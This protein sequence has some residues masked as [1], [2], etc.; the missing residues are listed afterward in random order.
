MAL[1]FLSL[2]SAWRMDEDHGQIKVMPVLGGLAPGDWC[3]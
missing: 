1:P 3:L 2:G